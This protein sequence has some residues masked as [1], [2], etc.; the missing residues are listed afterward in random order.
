MEL[1]SGPNWDQYGMPSVEGHHGYT[2]LDRPWR[3]PMDTTALGGMWMPQTSRE[4]PQTDPPH[5]SLHPKPPHR[6]TGEGHDPTWPPVGTSPQAFDLHTFVAFDMSINLIHLEDK[7]KS[8]ETQALIMVH[9]PL[10]GLS[11]GSPLAW[12]SPD[13]LLERFLK[14][15]VSL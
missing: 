4:S 8:G 2:G 13:L 12:L 5:G 11:P 3:N 15:L 9:T 10:K 1:S 6:S 7:Q 14:V